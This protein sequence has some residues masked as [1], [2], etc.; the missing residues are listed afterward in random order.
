[1]FQF[2]HEKMQTLNLSSPV[3]ACSFGLLYHTRSIQRPQIFQHFNLLPAWVLTNL[4][5]T[6]TRWLHICVYTT[7]YYYSINRHWCYNGCRTFFESTSCLRSFR[8]ISWSFNA[9]PDLCFRVILLRVT[10]AISVV[11]RA[12]SK[13][14]MLVIQTIQSTTI[15]EGGNKR[16]EY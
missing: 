9:G 11:T 14:V 8:T 1:M 13:E 3:F 4:H 5:P 12:R 6:R 16:A 7:Y 2:L 15:P 10:C